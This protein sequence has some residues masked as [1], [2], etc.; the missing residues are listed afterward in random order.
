MGNLDYIDCRGID[1]VVSLNLYTIRKRR[2]DFLTALL[3]KS[4]H[5]IAPHYISDRI[6]MRFDI[7]GYGTREASQLPFI[8]LLST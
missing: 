7:H 6:A 8:F 4:I 5:G 1:L 2:D 3:F